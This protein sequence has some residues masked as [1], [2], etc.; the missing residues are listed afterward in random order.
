MENKKEIYSDIK[1]L[2]QALDIIAIQDM[3]IGKLTREI[4]FNQDTIYKCRQSN[5]ERKKQAGYNDSVSFDDV[6]NEVFK[7]A[8]DYE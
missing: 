1:T 3:K 7:K 8:N 5:S 2:D 4:E 6:W